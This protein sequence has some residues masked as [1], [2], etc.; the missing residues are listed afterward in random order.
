MARSGTIV[1]GMF[2]R[3]EDLEQDERGR[4]R[5]KAKAAEQSPPDQGGDE[6]ADEAEQQTTPPDGQGETGGNNLT[7]P[8]Q[9]TVDG[10]TG[11]PSPADQGGDEKAA[12]QED[13]VG[14]SKPAGPA[15]P[16]K[17]YGDKMISHGGTPG[18]SGSGGKPA[19]PATGTKGS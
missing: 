3:W 16:V 19:S 13:Q 2:Y 12:D 14:K 11:E 5:V 1:D 8:D 18:A 10:G 15:R 9:A 17:N 7:S 6:K 4:W